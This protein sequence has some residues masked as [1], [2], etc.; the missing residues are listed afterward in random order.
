MGGQVDGRR[1][2]PREHP[3]FS[4]SPPAA[5]GARLNGLRF[6]LDEEENVTFID[7]LHRVREAL[8]L[9][10]ELNLIAKRPWLAE[11]SDELAVAMAQGDKEPFD[12]FILLHR[13]LAPYF[14]APPTRV[15]HGR[16]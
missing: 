3:F 11:R 10:P 13:P 6:T 4:G 9:S 8:D 12:A 2:R 16:R 14:Q 15:W 5:L 7:A 1:L